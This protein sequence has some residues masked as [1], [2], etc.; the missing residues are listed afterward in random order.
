MKNRVGLFAGIGLLSAAALALEIY[1]TRV[2]AILLGPHTA[3]GVVSIALLGIGAAGTVL[4]VAWR[5]V[6]ERP[7]H[8]MAACAL[9][10]GLT[11]LVGTAAVGH[12]PTASRDGLLSLATQAPLF[13]YYV[14]SAAP[15]FFAGCAFGLA[16]RA[17]AADAGRIYCA[18]LGG[19]AG[20]ALLIL[21]A[22][23]VI[24]GPGALAMTAVLAALAA[25]A[26]AG[27]S[28]RGII[29]PAALAG[30]AVIAVAAAPGL[31]YVQPQ[32][33][34]FL[35]DVT[36]H[37]YRLEKQYWSAL[38]RVDVTGRAPG[39]TPEVPY[40]VRGMSPAYRGGLPEVKWLTVDGD[41]ETPVVAF[42][43]DYTRL[44]FLDYYLPGLP[45]QYRPP[46]DVLIIGCGG[47]VD[48]L[49]ALRW[50]ARR[51]D[52]VEINPGIVAADKNDYAAFN[53][54]VF[55][56]PGV[57]LYNAEGRSFLRSSSKQYDLI[58]LSPVDTSTAAVSGA[59]ARAEDYLYT[60][61]AFQSYYRHLKP[62]GILT[63][64]RDYSPFPH[65]S[66]RLT[67]LAYEALR[68]E[69][70]VRP[71]RCIAVF[72]NGL[73]ANVIVQRGGFNEAEATALGGLAAGK[74]EPLWL[75][76]TPVAAH[77]FERLYRNRVWTA[78]FFVKETPFSPEE[79]RTLDADALAHGYRKLYTSDWLRRTTE[80]SAYLSARDKRAFYDRY[81]Y[82]VRPP[83]DDK[84]FYFLTSKWRNLYLRV[85][86]TS[87]PGFLARGNFSALQYP[88]QL[89]Q[90][91]ALVEAL[92]LS[93][94]FVV[95]PLW[96]VKRRT[97]AT[98]GKYAFA[99]YF[100]LLGV[101]FMFVEI[102]LIQKF[103]LYLGHPAYAFA[104]AL[105]TILGASSAGSLASGRSG[106]WR[107]WLPFAGAA[108]LAL[109][110]PLL[111]DRL[112][113]A[114][115]A[116]A[117][118]VRVYITV[119]LLA[120]IGF[121][122]GMPFPLGISVLAGREPALIPWAWATNSCASV[123]GPL[124]AVLIAGSGGHNAVLALAAAAYG[125]AWLALRLAARTQLAAPAAPGG[126]PPGP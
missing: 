68:R 5:R 10:F 118:G 82:D 87:P 43:G 52:A 14:I 23:G 38:G 74:F 27:F 97:V 119:A 67:A 60:G 8:V 42:D 57:T 62:R 104:V 25:A 64:T 46:T 55:R 95:V 124:A 123:L 89:F 6:M 85:A 28:R 93:V 75:P 12:F 56:R 54:G 45:Y 113:A 31:F 108:A 7:A 71:E 77:V 2:Y 63:V 72:T 22:M 37:G 83:R 41:A 126:G 90:L 33:G 16:F 79:G 48:V 73:Q 76:D 94:V 24:G 61:E 49:N 3:F 47:G 19:A 102:P 86:V 34:K 91:M 92:L 17:Y 98:G 117:W 39:S 26:F 9:G 109:L 30:A 110:Y 18:G 11:A 51:V 101:G 66:L 80:F 40:S 111:I 84:P 21:A 58:Q 125:L 103:T 29:L 1:L 107:W 50:G 105:A 53:G 59:H 81:F 120:P 112:L 36:G 115:L 96:L 4:T 122:L 70:E 78:R 15:F 116:W 121:C 65:E 88:A 99:F 69:G 44:G 20:G 32:P 114:T 106:K 35:P 13:A 100:L